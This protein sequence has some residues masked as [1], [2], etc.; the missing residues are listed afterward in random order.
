MGGLATPS[1]SPLGTS[2]GGPPRARREAPRGRSS[3]DAAVRAPTHHHLHT[4][5]QSHHRQD[6]LPAVK[7]A[8]AE[9]QSRTW[10]SGTLSMTVANDCS[11]SGYCPSRTKASP[12][13]R[14]ILKRTC[15]T[16]RDRTLATATRPAPTT[17]PP[18]LREPGAQH[19]TA[20]YGSPAFLTHYAWDAARLD[21]CWGLLFCS[22]V[23]SPIRS[24]QCIRASSLVP[25]P[26]H[27]PLPPPPLPC[28]YPLPP[29]WQ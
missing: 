28:P 24:R 23:H 7:V 5:R 8:S 9:P 18:S 27:P 3:P 20:A 15:T 14:M 29:P 11:A 25:F 12:M 17:L 6:T 22:F 1:V 16:A 13:L 21:R 4:I 26:V 10:W 2:T 19:V